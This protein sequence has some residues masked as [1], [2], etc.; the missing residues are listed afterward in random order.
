MPTDQEHLTSIR[1]QTLAMLAELT[2][3]PKPS[4]TIDGQSV[5]WNDYLLRLRETVDWCDRQLAAEPVELHSRGV[6]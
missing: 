3:A 1:G 2:A 5:S 6:T 4:Y